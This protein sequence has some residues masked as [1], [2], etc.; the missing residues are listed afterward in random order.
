MRKMIE[1]Q[2]IT[3]FFERI[4]DNLYLTHCQK[5]NMQLENLDDGLFSLDESESIRHD[6]EI[7]LENLK[8]ERSARQDEVDSP[9]STGRSQ[10]SEAKSLPEIANGA[11]LAL[12]GRIKE[13]SPVENDSGCGPLSPRVAGTKS[14]LVQKNQIGIRGPAE[15]VPNTK[16]LILA[17]EIRPKVAEIPKSPVKGSQ[18]SANMTQGGLFN[19][20]SFV[21]S[22]TSYTGSKLMPNLKKSDAF[23]WNF[24]ISEE[25]ENLPEDLDD[26]ITRV[27]DT[28]NY[29]SVLPMPNKHPHSYANPLDQK[30][31]RGSCATKS[32]KVK[33]LPRRVISNTVNIAGDKNGN[34]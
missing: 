29:L 8:Q 16:A 30:S 28:E 10:L 11:D 7:A 26:I 23:M 22:D 5:I 31:S 1:Q 2:E 24:K 27:R 19:L 4:N 18:N 34:S 13:T 15:P 25:D 3:N 14:L 17:Q 20:G 6:F 32:F 9:D 21:D 33:S 12:E